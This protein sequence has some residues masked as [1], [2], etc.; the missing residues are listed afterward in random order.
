LWPDLK[1]ELVKS[2]IA[3]IFELAKLMEDEKMSK[4][5][6]EIM[7]KSR[8]TE[9]GMSVYEFYKYLLGRDKLVEEFIKLTKK[10]ATLEQSY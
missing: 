3:Y 10:R 6:A 2:E 1:T 8:K 4:A 9:E 7:V 5:K